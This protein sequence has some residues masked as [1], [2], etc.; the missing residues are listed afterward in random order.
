[1][2]LA[3]RTMLLAGEGMRFGEGTML[4]GKRTRLFG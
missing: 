4:F 2:S 1:M 3:T